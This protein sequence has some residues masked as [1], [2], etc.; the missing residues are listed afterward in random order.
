MRTPYPNELYHHG[1]TGQKW[2]VRNG[3]PYPLYEGHRN[4]KAVRA[5]KA[6][7]GFA[8]KV[9]ERGLHTKF[10]K[11]MAFKE[12]RSIKKANKY[13]VKADKT[14]NERRKE[15]L[16]DKAQSAKDIADRIAN[17]GKKYYSLDSKDQKTISR[18]YRYLT[19]RANIKWWATSNEDWAH[20]YTSRDRAL[21]YEGAEAKALLEIEEA[22]KKKNK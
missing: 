14:N 19:R 15:R 7:Y 9:K 5:S 1:V 16:S 21:A 18:G 17:S 20:R 11:D 6:K 22:Y 2:G 3:P 10:E 13:S 12:N 4:N 8:A